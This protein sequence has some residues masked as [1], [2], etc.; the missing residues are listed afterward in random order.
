[1]ISDAEGIKRIARSHR[2][3]L[4]N[5]FLENPIIRR[6]QPPDEISSSIDRCA[7]RID[8]PEIIFKFLCR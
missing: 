1:M 2:S 3:R 7:R 4:W 8:G 6:R 5:F